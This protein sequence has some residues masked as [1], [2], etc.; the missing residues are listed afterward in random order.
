MGGLGFVGELLV[1]GLRC[2]LFDWEW[3]CCVDWLCAEVIYVFAYFLFLSFVPL[4][5]WVASDICGWLICGYN[6]GCIYLSILFCF[7]LVVQLSVWR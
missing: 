7:L 3:G 4:P 6:F 5:G 1:L 2:V